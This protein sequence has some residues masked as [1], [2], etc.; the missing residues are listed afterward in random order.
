MR[1]LVAILIVLF[2]LSEGMVT[3]ITIPDDR[4]KPKVDKGIE[5]WVLNESKGNITLH[6]YDEY[7]MGGLSPETG[8]GAS[9][10]DRGGEEMPAPISS[11][12]QG[13]GRATSPIVN[14]TAQCN[15]TKT[16]AGKVQEQ[17]CL[18]MGFGGFVLVSCDDKVCHIAVNGTAPAPAV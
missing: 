13:P 17:I 1:K 18:P 7:G 16:P 9:S 4:N 14:E 5:S 8:I 2:A 3:G 10:S 6:P 11:W 12:I 15:C